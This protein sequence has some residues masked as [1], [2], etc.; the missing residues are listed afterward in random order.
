MEIRK[1]AILQLIEY[2]TP[3]ASFDIF[4]DNHFTSFRLLTHHNKIRAT[5]VL[6]T[7]MRYHWEQTAAKKKKHGHLEQRTSSKS[8]VTLVVVD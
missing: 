4:M 1:K 2:L 8:S 6:V 5:R 3:T 7:Q